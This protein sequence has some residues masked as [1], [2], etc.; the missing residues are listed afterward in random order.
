MTSVKNYKNN[1][2]DQSS[3]RVDILA[4]VAFPVTDSIGLDSD[5]IP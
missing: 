1:I 4:A 2:T 3:V 5:K